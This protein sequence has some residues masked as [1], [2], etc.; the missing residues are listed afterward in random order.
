MSNNKNGLGKLNAG[1]LAELRAIV[2]RVIDDGDPHRPEGGNGWQ[3]Y[4]DE[5]VSED[6]ADSQR[7]DFCDAIQ[8]AVVAAAAPAT[9]AKGEQR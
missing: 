3:M 9:Q 6:Y 7:L 2:L 1:D 5:D 8:A 4:E